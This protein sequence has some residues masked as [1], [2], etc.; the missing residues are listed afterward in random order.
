VE[1]ERKGVADL[2]AW[3]ALRAQ[4]ADLEALEAIHK[5]RLTESLGDAQAATIGGAIVLTY[6]SHE[7][8]NIDLARLRREHPDIAAELSA[9]SSVRVLRPVRP[10]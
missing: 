6:R 2:E 1:L 4:L 5:A 9:T 8:T 7:R 10:L 3:L